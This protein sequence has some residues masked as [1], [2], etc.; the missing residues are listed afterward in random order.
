[1]AGRKYFTLSFDDGLEQDK[2]ITAILKSYGLHCCTF[3]LNAGLMGRKRVITQTGEFRFAETD[4]LGLL[5]DPSVRCA[6]HFR[7]PKDEIAEVYEGFE[8]A[9]HTYLHQNLLTLSG[10]ALDECIR[11]DVSELET[12]TGQP[13]VGF[14]YPYGGVNAQ[15]IGV[16]KQYGIR[17]ARGVKSSRGF[18]LPEDP[19]LLQ[20]TCWMIERDVFELTER[21]LREE[22]RKEDQVL[23]VWGHGYEFDL[24]PGQ[25]G[26]DC[27]KR[28]C[29]LICSADDVIPCT[30]R[31]IYARQVC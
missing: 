16:L 4:D 28:L 20:P 9:S 31:E 30:N 18:G 25:I 23:C 5:K 29:E 17:Y 10:D 27:L 19:Y 11:R 21:F 1:M 13:V 6:R 12:L 22:S 14:A 24:A 7:I 8:I 3:N 15:A 26:W 2:R